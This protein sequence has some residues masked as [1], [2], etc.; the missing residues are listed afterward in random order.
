MEGSVDAYLTELN[1]QVPYFLP[2]ILAVYAAIMGSFLNCAVYRVPR[3]ISLRYPPSVCP[4]CDTRLKVL[5]LVPILSWLCLRGKCRH[6][7]KSISARYMWLEVLCV[8]W[9]LVGWW[10]F[11][12]SLDAL[13]FTLFGGGLFFSLIV[14]ISHKSLHLRV[15]LFS[16]ITLVLIAV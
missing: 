9:A 16:L 13:W 14:Y 15:L 11:G 5:D 12:P 6:C 7:Q 3:G 8:V 4:S 2:T 1:W 10:L